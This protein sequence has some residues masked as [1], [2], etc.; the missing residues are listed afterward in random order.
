MQLSQAPSK[1]SAP[2]Q[3]TEQ[4]YIGSRRLADDG[5]VLSHLQITCVINLTESTTKNPAPAVEYVHVPV[6]DSPLTRLSDHF[7][8]V[9]EKIHHVGEQG[10]RTLVHCNAGVSRSATVCLAYMMKFHSMS[11][12]E[13]HKRVKACRPI[14][15][16]NS[17]FWKQLIEYE[18][19]LHGSATVKMISTPLG[20]IPD[21][22]ERETKDL[23]PC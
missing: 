17:G 6:S 11:L 8:S 9:A 19:C 23:I 1:L 16:P 4:L 10:G 5:A 12:I 13:A 3:V 18:F 7:D 20:D 22:Y 15:R 14:I 2:G 21:L